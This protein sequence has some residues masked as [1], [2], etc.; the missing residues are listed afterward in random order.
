MTTMSKTIFR[1]IAIAAAVCLLASA[2]V[3]QTTS[4]PRIVCD[5]PT[6]DFGE[7]Q[8]FETIE[9]E[10]VLRN[11]GT[12]PLVIQNVRASCGC[13]VATVSS[14]RIESG[15]T[16]VVKASLSLRGRRGVQRKS[17]SIE[18]NDPAHS[19]YM[20][21]LN[22]TAI[23]EVGME[24][25]YVNFGQVVSDTPVSREATLLSRDPAIDIVSIT[26]G[27]PGFTA[28]VV[29]NTEGRPRAVK[30]TATPPFHQGFHRCEYV[31]TTTHPT[32]PTLTLPVSL[33]VPD[34]L[35]VIPR[36]IV[37]RGNHPEGLSRTLLIRPGTGRSFEVTG[38]RVPDE[39]ITSEVTSIGSGNYRVVLSG[40]PVSQELDGTFVEIQT[41]LRG[42][43]NVRVPIYVTAP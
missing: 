1:T 29:N 5:E 41:S 24:P 16:T 22:G 3:G 38:V 13:T 18:S 27:A 37:L 33:L 11:D 15:G 40:L 34:P 42:F 36:S 31:V 28:T 10:F 17:I 19:T 20:L 26:G 23:I 7:R 43:E 35:Y 32:T 30:I 6:F 4:H 12:A 39:R 14:R 2:G 9:H 25:S 8:D 21:W